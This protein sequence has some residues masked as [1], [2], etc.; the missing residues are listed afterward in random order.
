[1]TGI[2]KHERHLR[3]LAERH[4]QAADEHDGRHDQDAQQHDQHVLDLRDV[5]GGARIQA[6]VAELVKFL[7]GEALGLAED[8]ASQDTAEAHRHL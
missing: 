5:V 6:G 3:A 4:D 8:L 7:E 1:M 2:V